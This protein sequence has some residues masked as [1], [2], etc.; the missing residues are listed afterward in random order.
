VTNAVLEAGYYILLLYLIV[1]WRSFTC[2][3]FDQPLQW[4]LKV[5]QNVF[6]GP[7]YVVADGCLV[8]SDMTQ[9]QTR[10]RSASLVAILVAFVGLVSVRLQT[11]YVCLVP[12]LLTNNYIF[13]LVTETGTKAFTCG[14]SQILVEGFRS[15]KIIFI[16]K[17]KISGF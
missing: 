16:G 17:L 15:W 5:M 8:I 10:R 4:T 7:A 9:H 11:N 2:S 13:V 1:T 3:R 12:Y 14:S 6:R